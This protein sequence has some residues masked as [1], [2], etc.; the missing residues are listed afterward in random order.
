MSP[1]FFRFI[2]ALAPLV[3]CVA[4]QQVIE[5]AP[6]SPEQ[7]QLD[8]YR[9]TLSSWEIQVGLHCQSP[10]GKN[11]LDIFREMVRKQHAIEA[12]TA[13]HGHPDARDREYL[14]NGNYEDA[15]WFSEDE[16][17]R[18]A[19]AFK[20]YDWRIFPVGEGGKHRITLKFQ[21]DREVVEGWAGTVTQYHT[22]KTAWGTVDHSTCKPTLLSIS[23]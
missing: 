8:E 11:S 2:S 13:L 9:K 16:E 22:Y 7:Q 20:L 10:I 4:C 18:G 14:E 12:Y 23:D 15:T 17:L 3:L 21:T 6:P 19:M 5:V 1:R